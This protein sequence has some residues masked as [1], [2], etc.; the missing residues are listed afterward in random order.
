MTSFPCHFCLQEPEPVWRAMKYN[1]VLE[2]VQKANNG[3]KALLRGKKRSYAVGAGHMS[4][5]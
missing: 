5:G 1:D 3:Y 2:M 4:M